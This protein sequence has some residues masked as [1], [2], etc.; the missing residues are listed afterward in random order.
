[1]NALIIPISSAKHKSEIPFTSALT[2]F[3]FLHTWFYA[4]CK[5]AR[6]RLLRKLYFLAVWLSQN[7]QAKFC[8]QKIYYTTKKSDAV[9]SPFLLKGGVVGKAFSHCTVVS[10]LHFW[11]LFY[12]SPCLLHVFLQIH[13]RCKLSLWDKQQKQ[14]SKWY[15]LRLESPYP[16]GHQ[17]WCPSHRLTTSASSCPW[18]PGNPGKTPKRTLTW[19]YHTDILISSSNVR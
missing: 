1:M 16:E 13:I 4:I 5:R 6:Q 14:D 12:I 19:K 3:Y 10:H 17:P 7:T 2:A 9:K 8:K 18:L 15:H 11:H